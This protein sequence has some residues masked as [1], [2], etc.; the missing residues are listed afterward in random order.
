MS[1]PIWGRIIT[2][3]FDLQ[4]HGEVPCAIVLT[5]EQWAAVR[6]EWRFGF[7]SGP[8]WEGERRI[9]GI[10]VALVDDSY[11]GPVVLGSRKKD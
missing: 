6:A 9:N 8:K 7:S 3:A 11:T 2:E 4:K 5:E 1:T 10:C